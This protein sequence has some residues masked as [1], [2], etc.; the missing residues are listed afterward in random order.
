MNETIETILNHRSIRKFKDEKLTEEQ[1]RTLVE[2]AQAAPTSSYVQAYSIIGV[3]DRTKREQLAKIA[4]DQPYVADN[5]HF[6]VFCADYY[7]H[8][9]IAEWKEREITSSIEGT[10]Q[11]MVAV[12]DATLAAQNMAVAAESLG[13]GYCYIGGLRNNLEGVKEVLETP[14][15]VLPLF[16]FAV[17]VPAHESSKKPRLP[18]EHIY[19]ENTYESD[20]TKQKTGIDEFDATVKA[21]YQE[22]SGNPRVETWSEQM[23]RLL[24]QD[25]RSYM[26]DFVEAQK[27]KLR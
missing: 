9:K 23:M 18:F 14:E 13:L 2:A 24:E 16:G 7:R 25:R 5:G 15:R 27:F 4:G 17:G 20:V 6:F 1:V 11:F 8:E 19:H 3:T 22:R 21:Y 26:K 12:I 10:E